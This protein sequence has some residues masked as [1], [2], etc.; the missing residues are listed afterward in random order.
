MACYNKHISLMCRLSHTF[1]PI[2]E[3][4]AMDRRKIKTQAQIKQV[5]IQL[6]AQFQYSD[7]D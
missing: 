7:I 1:Q 5:F 4:Q 3:Q 2:E 6:L